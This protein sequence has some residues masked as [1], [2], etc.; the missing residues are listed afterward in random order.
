MEQYYANIRDS[1]DK[2]GC[3]GGLYYTVFSNVINENNF[4]VVAEVGIGYGMHARQLL[5]DTSIEKLFLVD[6]SKP[7]P[8]DGFSVD[9]LMN[10]GFEALVNEIK[11]ELSPYQNR[12]EWIRKP[13]LEVTDEE[14]PDES[15]DAVFID[16]DHSYEAVKADLDK[17]WPKIR[18]GGQLLGD[19]YSSCHPGVPQAV[20][21]FA[22]KHNIT[23]DFLFKEGQSYPIYRFKKN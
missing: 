13:S 19:D 21:E 12:Y 5:R 17:W 9:V 11:K 20:N 1:T 16:G 8:N 18:N 6:P 22:K 2:G 23:Y 4:K 15:L 14:I 10:G 3:W 7:Y